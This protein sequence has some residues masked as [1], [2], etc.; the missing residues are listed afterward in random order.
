MKKTMKSEY[1]YNENGNID[2]SVT[3]ETTEDCPHSECDECEG[4]ELLTGEVEVVSEVSET[5]ATVALVLATVGLCLT[6]A[7]TLFKRH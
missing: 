3:T 7:N 5:L 4:G 2:H 6:V 1:F